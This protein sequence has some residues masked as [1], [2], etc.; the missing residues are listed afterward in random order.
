MNRTTNYKLCQW[1]ADDKIQRVDF[2]ED[3]AK[4]D[5]AIKAVDRRADGLNTAKADKTAL[6]ALQTVVNGKGNC[7]I[8]TGSYVGDGDKHR[9]L[10]ITTSFPPQVVLVAGYNVGIAVRGSETFR[11]VSSTLRTG[12]L[13]WRDDGIS[14]KNYNGYMDAAELLN[15][16]NGTFFWVAFG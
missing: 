4:I 5:A 3:N 10:S 14:W 16:Q 8:E 15:S 7:R 6:T 13:T 11:V 1:E 2:N 9:V 12:V